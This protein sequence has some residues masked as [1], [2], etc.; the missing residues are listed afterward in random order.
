MNNRFYLGEMAYGKSARKSVGSKSGKAVPKE[1]WK[2]IPNHH[3]ALISEE[4]FE[5]VSAYR[6]GYSTKR[7]R[8]KHPL[9]GK[10]YC[11]GCGYSLNYKP[12]RKNNK[13]RHFECRKHA[14]L[15][16]PECCTYMNANLLEET[17]LL[18]LNKELMLWG[19]AVKQ[20]ENLISF[21]KAGIHAL[22]MKLEG[23]KQEKKLVQAEKD[24]LY[25][26]YALTE[27]S[28]VEYQKKAKEM[29]ER[30]SS[31]SVEEAGAAEK[32]ESLER[33]YQKAEEDMKQVI[34]Y[35]HLEKLTQDVVDAFIKKVY[36]YKD[37]RVEI[38][39]NFS[40]GFWS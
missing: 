8:E 13:Y 20:K 10:L 31:L 39:W 34:R 32:L 37:K 25:E 28:V 22:K 35:S 11:G 15:Q 40:M 33:E 6:T 19:N 38:E 16:I 17:V 29:T 4:I 2:V 27:I 1:K 18:M 30:M 3:E 24:T 14:L 7:N 23:Y 5:E 26:R 12:I 9:T 36:V 21:Q